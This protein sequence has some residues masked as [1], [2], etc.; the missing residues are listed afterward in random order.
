MISVCVTVIASSEL[1]RAPRGRRGGRVGVTALP[2]ESRAR[3]DEAGDGRTCM[4]PSESARFVMAGFI[5]R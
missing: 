5:L 4:R 2:R 3:R 1:E